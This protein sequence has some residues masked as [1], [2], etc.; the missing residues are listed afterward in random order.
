MKSVA[1]LLLFLAVTIHVGAGIAR[2]NESS[3]HHDLLIYGAT[4]GGVAMAV[5]AAREGLDVLLVSHTRH[6]G[7]MLTN[8]L[9]TM[10][11]L[12]NGER[13]PLYDELR[14]RISDFYRDKY[15][16]DSPQYLATQ[17]GHPKTRYEAHVVERLINELLTAE[18]QITLLTE[19]YPVEATREDSILQTVTF[20]QMDGSARVTFSA[21]VFADC[22]YEAD[23]AAIAKVPYRVGREARDEFD[24]PHAG[25]IYMR[26]VP[27]PPEH[28]ENETFQ[29]ARGLNLF[30]YTSWYE[31]IGNVST[32][33]A[34][35]AVQGYNLRTIVTRDP[36]NR[37]PIEKPADYDPEFLKAYGFGNPD[38]PGLS[39]PNQKSG[40]NH[41][42]LVGQQDPYVEGDWET[43]ADVIRKH[44]DATLALLYYRQHDPSVPEDIRG[45]WQTYGLPRDEFADNGHMPYEIY[46]RETR[47][48]RGRAVFTEHDA[49]LAPG[50]ERAPVHPTS[51]SITEWFLDSHACTPRDVPG[52]EQ[53]GMVMLKN[54]T[55]PGQVPF[56]T[57][58]P[59][60]LDN[61][62]V[63]VCL[64]ATH[65]GWGTIRLEPTWM[66][67]CEAAA[68][69]VVLAKRQHVTPAQI[70]AD[71]LVRQLADR[72]VMLSFFNDIE[73]HA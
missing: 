37:L 51:I 56:Q 33:A 57:L 29:L 7:G 32:G 12:Y 34:H 6:L 38:H 59:E 4:P 43:R 60:N 65:V 58:L 3:A 41:P 70:N 39:M 10:D 50:L 52:S 40:L 27:W 36:A 23:L 72:R 69:A 48:I 1:Q 44:R 67:I 64:S 73:G 19:Y 63:P 14:Q 15:G 53:E 55:F 21:D 30:R 28:V 22:S 42:K 18:E 13:A 35:P 47:R 9:S 5:R 61:L 68:H 31:T 8:G 25:V 20:Q 66:S 24:E 26:N 62:L 46:A 45:K 71:E 11:T 49:R 2:S 16:N 54:Q 17:P